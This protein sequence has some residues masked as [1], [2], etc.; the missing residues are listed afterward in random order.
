[1][2]KDFKKKHN[3]L[4]LSRIWYSTNED[5]GITPEK[6]TKAGL[7]KEDQKITK[8]TK[9]FWLQRL[10]KNYLDFK[11]V[12]HNTT[13]RKIRDVILNTNSWKRNAKYVKSEIVIFNLQKSCTV[14]RVSEGFHEIFRYHP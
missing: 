6:F 9:Y 4:K 5:I 1:M 3:S 2:N 7:A 12:V 11:Q 14:E 10:S 13:I 8:A